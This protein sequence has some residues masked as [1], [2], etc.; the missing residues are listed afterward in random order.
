VQDIG[1]N[2]C[3][4][5]V[6]DANAVQPHAF[7]QF[8]QH[9]EVG[10]AEHQAQVG[11]QGVEI[12]DAIRPFF[13]HRQGQTENQTFKPG[14]VRH[15]DG[16]R[17]GVFFPDS[18]HGIAHRRRH[19]DHVVRDGVRFFDEIDHIAM[20][21]VGEDRE[22]PLEDMAEGQK[23]EHLVAAMDG[24]VV[25]DG[26]W[27]SRSRCRGSAWHPWGGRWSPRCRSGRTGPSGFTCCMRWDRAIRGIF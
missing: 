27:P 15:P 12:H 6:G 1:G 25:G 3:G 2:G 24:V 21:D 10:Q 17:R 26:P 4:P 9:G 11:R 22:E 7:F 5:R 14:G 13:T 20:G 16:G 19:F 23:R 18:R 8:A